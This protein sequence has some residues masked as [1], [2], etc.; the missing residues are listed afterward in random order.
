MAK[1]PHLRLVE[2]PTVETI[3]ITPAA[4][5]EYRQMALGSELGSLKDLFE[6]FPDL[7]TGEEEEWIEDVIKTCHRVANLSPEG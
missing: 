6:E 4:R 7:E 3:A 1:R 5:E 2:S